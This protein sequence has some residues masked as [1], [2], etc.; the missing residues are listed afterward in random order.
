MISSVKCTP[1]NS[2]CAQGCRIADLKLFVL[3]SVRIGRTCLLD[4]VVEAY[5]GSTAGSG[6]GGSWSCRVFCVEFANEDLRVKLYAQATRVCP[7]GHVIRRSLV[8]DIRPKESKPCVASRAIAVVWW[9]R[10]CLWPALSATVEVL[11]RF[12]LPHCAATIVA[13]TIARF[14]HGCLSLVGSGPGTLSMSEGEWMFA[15]RIISRGGGSVAPHGGSISRGR[16]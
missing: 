5:A 1:R 3:R 2:D 12:V 9:L 14:L 13:V 16:G 4:S 7:S 10:G 8:L 11:A 15:G 6:P